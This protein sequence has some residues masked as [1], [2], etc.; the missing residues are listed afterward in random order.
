MNQLHPGHTSPSAP[1]GPPPLWQVL[2]AAGGSVVAMT[3]AVYFA[4]QGLT[5]IALTGTTLFV[6]L[7]GL[8][9]ELAR[10]RAQAAD[11]ARR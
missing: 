8:S 4:G 3:A 11:A 7:G 6:G 1:S 2:A 5:P 10:R 9:F